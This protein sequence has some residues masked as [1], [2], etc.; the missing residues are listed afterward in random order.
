MIQKLSE[1]VTDLYLAEG[2]K[3]DQLWKRIVTALENLKVP[4]A[5]IEFIVNSDNPALLAKFLNEK[6][7]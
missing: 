1:M 6:E 7:W 4:A 3:R 5:R 2:K